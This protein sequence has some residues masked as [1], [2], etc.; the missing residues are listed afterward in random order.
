MNPICS[1]HNVEMNWRPPGQS[2]STGKPYPG[3]WACPQKN[4][5]GSYCNFKPVM[6]T[7]QNAPAPQ[8]SPPAV[9]N[10]S[11]S[12]SDAVV[13]LLER[14]AT[15]LERIEGRRG[16]NQDEIPVIEAEEPNNLPF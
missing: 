12:A 1:V 6:P 14:I 11:S 13:K 9:P 7:P 5:D 4:P 10:P 8:Y 3:F 2:R 15:T 16:W